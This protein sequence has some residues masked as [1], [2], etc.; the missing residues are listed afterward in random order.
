MFCGPLLDDN[1]VTAATA[2]PE[3]AYDVA[4]LLQ[5]LG[6]AVRVAHP[7]SCTLCNA[8]SDLQGSN[9]SV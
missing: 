1:T 5:A 4:S 9:G 6:K 7:L 8:L 2:V 3:S